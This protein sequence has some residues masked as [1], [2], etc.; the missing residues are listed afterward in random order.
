MVGGKMNYKTVILIVVAAL[1]VF[2][3]FEFLLT[4]RLNLMVNVEFSEQLSTLYNKRD[5]LPS[6]G[7][8]FF[9][10]ISGQEPGGTIFEKRIIV[11]PEKNRYEINNIP[12]GDYFYELELDDKTITREFINF[13][14]SFRFTREE[15]GI[16]LDLTNLATIT[17]V[18]YKVEDPSLLIKWHGKYMGAFRPFQYLVKTNNQ[19]E[20]VSANFLRVDL[21][22]FLLEDQREIRLSIEPLTKSGMPLLQYDK[23]IPIE[24]ASVE[25]EIPEA[26]NPYELTVEIQGKE[27]QIDPFTDNVEIPLAG[28]KGNELS[29]P[30]NAKYYGETI[31][32]STVDATS[33]RNG[34][35]FPEVP[36][37]TVTTMSFNEDALDIHFALTGETS[38]LKQNFEYFVVT[39]ETTATTCT[40]SLNY[41][42]SEKGE[43]ITVKPYFYPDIMGEAVRFTVPLDPAPRLHSVMFDQDGEFSPKLVIYSGT[44]ARTAGRYSIDREKERTIPAFTKYETII[45]DDFREEAVHHV[46]VVLESEYD[47][48][49]S[50]EKWISTKSPEVTFFKEAYFDNSGI[51]HVSWDQTEMYDELKLIV[52]DGYNIIEKTPSGSSA[53]I[54]I[55]DTALQTP[56]RIILKGFYQ[57]DEYTAAIVENLE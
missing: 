12:Y 14:P 5:K 22:S 43:T 40:K 25:F 50:V 34:V 33:I 11:S 45:P 9:F 56:L 18:D 15:S 17:S 7:A 39:T 55:K 24:L 38:F 44:N 26:L 47:V 36:E 31:W 27:L 29:I 10:Q 57:G 49:G 46:S 16:A 23:T 30:F 35:E 4:S 6:A 51:L 20:S 19:E 28:S 32:N 2:T 53:S 41:E 48:Q 37:P 21:Y 8:N 3:L 1:L 54:N 42:F 13:S 52:T